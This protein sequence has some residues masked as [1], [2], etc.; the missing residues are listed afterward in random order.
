[1][2]RRWAAPPAG[3]HR[4]APGRIIEDVERATERLRS[5]NKSV[6][7]EAVA[8]A[9]GG[10][11]SGSGRSTLRRD[12]VISLALASNERSSGDATRVRAARSA[13]RLA[14]RF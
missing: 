14:A 6:L 11:A 8:E 10:R 4:R 9:L 3:Y 7:R 2:A 5:A 13:C 12:F 1:V